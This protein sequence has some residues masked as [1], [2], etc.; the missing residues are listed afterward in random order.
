M[1]LL[2]L[3]VTCVPPVVGCDGAPLQFP[4]QVSIML[5]YTIRGMAFSPDCPLDEMGQQQ[6]CARVVGG[7]EW[8]MQ[9]CSLLIDAM[10][11][12]RVGEVFDVQMPVAVNPAGRSDQC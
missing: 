7:G 3:L 12:P 9:G 8:A 11:D 6:A 5:P 2:A 4:E 10:P 1:T